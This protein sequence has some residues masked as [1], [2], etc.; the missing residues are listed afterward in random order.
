M[1]VMQLNLNHCEVAQQVL[2][3]T[4]VKE[5]VDVALLSEPYQVPV[6]DLSW[7]VD[8]TGKAAILAGGRYP[9]QSVDCSEHEGFVVATVNSVVCCSVYAPPSWPVVKFEEFL[10]KLSIELV[11]RGSVVV[12]GDFNAWSVEWGS[13]T[14]NQ[15]GSSVAECFATLDLQLLNDGGASTFRRNDRSSIVD[16][17]FC[18]QRLA[19]GADWR[20]LEDDTL[21][22]HQAIHFSVGHTRGPSESGYGVTRGWRTQCFHSDTFLADLSLGGFGIALTSA[23]KLVDVLSDACDATMPRRRPPSSKRR[24]KYWWNQVIKELRT[25]CTTA[26]RKQLRARSEVRREELKLVY[27]AA[28]SALKREI[29]ASKRRCFLDLCREAE[30]NVWGNAYRIVMDKLKGQ[31]PPESCPIRLRAIIEELFPQHDLTTRVLSSSPA[32]ELSAGAWGGRS[33]SGDP[34]GRGL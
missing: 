29:K 27:Q 3:Q 7:V 25:A 20:V 19:P 17:T 34:C 30:R 4:L 16:E 24:P 9:I 21:S 8:K 23:A 33:R 13:K 6:D 10:D 18:S 5:N 2:W 31:H 1:E 26:R 15:R 14:T 28:R 12:G 32:E 22:D 11:G